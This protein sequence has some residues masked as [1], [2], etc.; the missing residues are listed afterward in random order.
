[1]RQEYEIDL[2][3][4]LAGYTN[5]ITG[6]VMFAFPW[7]D[8]DSELAD[9]TGPND[10]QSGVLA[11]IDAGLLNINEAILLATTSGHGVGKSALV[12]WIVLWAMS[13]YEDTKGVVTAN[14]ETQLKTKTWAEVAKWYR[15]FVGKQYFKLTATALF[16]NDPDHEK[17]WRM[18]MV[19][20][21]EKNTEAFAGLHNKGKRILLIFDEGSAIPDLIW[22]VAEGA[23]TDK[24]TQIIW[25]VFGNP[26]RATGRFR[27][28]FA[29]GKFAHRWHSRKVDSRSVPQTNK[30]QLERWIKD[31]GE[32]HDFCRVRVKGEFPR[33]DA[34]SFISAE[35]ARE[36]T[37]RTIMEQRGQPVV[38]GVDVGRFGNDP[39]VIFP[40]KGRDA[41][42][43]PVEVY[44]S[45]DT[46]ALAKKVAECY[47][48]V[49][50]NFVFVDAGGVGGGV[51]DRL[52]QMLIPVIEVDFGAKPDRTN[53]IQTGVKYKNKRAEIWGALRDWLPTGKIPEHIRG[54]EG[55]LIDEISGPQYGMDSKE[56]IQL[57]SKAEMRRR[58]VDSPNVADALACTFAF[59]TEMPD[60]EDTHDG[61]GR[62]F[63]DPEMYP[64]HDPFELE[65]L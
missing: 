52:R 1:M 45:I 60:V 46:M 12:G 15:L 42:T 57:E 21:S 32:D 34:Q 8:P 53:E 30:K 39:S 29:P 23:L 27:E 10:F 9:E 50:A 65:R 37:V 6:F 38:L 2:L 51:V 61:Y 63:L 59:N 17:T 33:V 4:E 54:V 64:E 56:Q 25:A 16:S 26:T 41:C 19:P 47:R 62:N 22:E 58:G 40:R 36:A 43:I 28:C 48:R 55:T 7:G 44:P 31:Y 13:T 49:H 24:H 18:D 11:D 20:W 35:L 5:N 3:E 14:T